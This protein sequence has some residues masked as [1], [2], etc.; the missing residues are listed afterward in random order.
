M[1]KTFFCVILTIILTLMVG[2]QSLNDIKNNDDIAMKLGIMDE[3]FSISVPEDYEETSSDYIEK[4]FIKDNSASIIVTHE[5]NTYGYTN[6]TQYYDN[7]TLQYASTFDNFNEISKENITI[8]NLYGAIIAEF[9]YQIK[10][11][12]KLIDMTCYTEYILLGNTIYIITCSASTETYS[13]YKNDFIQT[14]NS[15]VITQ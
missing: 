4:Y 8:K 15:V 7:A 14:V 11:N 3:K 12:D 10:S 13:N 9:S 5:D 1:K 6:I 2:C